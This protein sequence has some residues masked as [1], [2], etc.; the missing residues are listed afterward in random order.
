[1][2]AYAPA[3]PTMPL[4]PLVVAFALA[5][6]PGFTVRSYSGQS[7]SATKPS[8]ALQTSLHFL[9]GLSTSARNQKVQRGFVAL[10]DWPE[11]ERTV[12][13]GNEASGR[14]R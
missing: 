8:Q 13:P 7:E 5:S 4:H 3:R 14:A 2:Y 6:F 11:Y 9:I 12:K 10:S 1:M